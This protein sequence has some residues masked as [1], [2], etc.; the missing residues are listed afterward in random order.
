MGGDGTDPPSRF[1]R[2]CVP[3]AARSARIPSPASQVQYAP[4][5]T[6]GA[7][8]YKRESHALCHYTLHGTAALATADG[9]DGCTCSA[10]AR[11]SLLPALAEGSKAGGHRWRARAD[12]KQTVH[13]EMPAASASG[14][15]A[16][17]LRRPTAGP[18]RARVFVCL[19][20]AP[21]IRAVY[22]PHLLRCS[23][24]VHLHGTLFIL[25]SAVYVSLLAICSPLPLRPRP[26]VAAAPALP[27]SPL[28][29]DFAPALCFAFAICSIWLL[30][31]SKMAALYAFFSQIANNIT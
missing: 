30:Y 31:K 13:V 10:R 28:L 7:H 20:G 24:F 14:G 25:C 19:H 29:S 15:G 9:P 12:T 16:V 8:Y 6:R 26:P 18:E 11:A 4:A 5:M 2:Y 27:P 17:A 22:S 23:M 3:G 21:H 1:S